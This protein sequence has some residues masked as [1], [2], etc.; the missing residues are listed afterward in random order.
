MDKRVYLFMMVAFVTGMVELIIGGILDLVA[1]DL[2]V[3]IGQAGLLITVFSI[4]FALS[5]PI[6]LVATSKMER[7]RL[8]L[9][10]LLV[11]LL[12]N[13]AV[14]MS[15]SYAMLI[16]ARILS[17]ASGSLLLVLCVTMASRIVT[18]PYRGRAIGIVFMGVSGS[19]V[20]GI[21]FGVF[22]GN[23]FGWRTPFL[24]IMILTAISMACVYVL[25]E[26]MEPRPQVSLRQQLATLRMRPV[27][28]AQLTSFIFFVGHYTL[29]GYLT[30][31]SKMTMGLDGTW[32]SIVYL[33]FGVAAVTGGGL[34]GM[35]SDRLG[36][37]RTI[38]FVVA[39]FAISLFVIPYT[40]F[41]LPVFLILL[42]IWSALSWALTPAMQSHLIETSP[43]TADIQQSLNNSSLHLG[44]AFGSLSG[45]IVIEQS[46]V[47]MNPTVG[48]VFVLL[49]LGAAIISIKAAQR[50]HIDMENTYEK[51]RA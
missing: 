33:V 38:L 34:G 7:K 11:F 31:F 27:L 10:S 24:L 48:G 36:S 46:S 37:R 6:L 19:L 41:A 13:L 3:S 12:G 20:F 35:L 49:A 32:V 50:R 25:M 43:E 44:I 39:M 26:K 16:L 47:D 14:V 45:S 42:I 9:L 22:L 29:Y 18:E 30:P 15:S 40:T 4:S 1:E 2:H 8:T 51:T 23:A 17:A 28:F 21:P 5:A